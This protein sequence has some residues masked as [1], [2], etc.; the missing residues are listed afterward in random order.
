MM[1]FEINNLFDDPQDYTLASDLS[2]SVLF[3]K[4]Q[5]ISDLCKLRSHLKNSN[6]QRWLLA[7][8]HPYLFA[9]GF[10]ALVSLQK[11]VVLSANRKSS[12]LNEIQQSFDGV[13]AEELISLE[14]DKCHEQLGFEQLASLANAKQK[15][16]VLTGKES[17]VFFTSGSTG[18]AK[19]VPK[20]LSYLIDEVAT[21]EK[22]F[23]EQLTNSVSVSSV[24]HFHIYGL[25]FNIL[26]PLL[27]QRLWLT[28]VV[29]FQE[30]LNGIAE[31]PNNLVFVSSPAFLSRLDLNSKFGQTRKIFS[32]GGPL[33]LESATNAYHVFG[34]RPTEVYGSTET[35]GIGYR[36]QVEENQPWQ[37]FDGVMLKPDSTG[38]YLSS[39]HIGGGSQVKLDDNIQLLDNRKFVLAGRNDRIV[40]IEEK[41][42]SLTEIEDYLRS[43]IDV[44]DCACVVLQSNR[45]IIGAVLVLSEEGL[46]DLQ[47]KGRYQFF[48]GL[49]LS[50]RTRFENV[51]IPRKWRILEELPINQQSKR[52]YSEMKKLFE[53]AR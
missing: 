39:P 38:T 35:G 49:K 24:S 2:G 17:V 25:L 29:E 9:I 21:L 1:N 18:K 42:I 32:S 26:W 19:E 14:V 11:T 36:S 30:Q 43:L 51:T 20:C 3:T 23:A 27:S 52:E 44:R 13:L 4:S 33:S 34:A 48:Q 37:L 7:Y 46:S 15:P 40:K 5:F 16:V 8:E 10:F 22:T 6:Q 53:K 12:W 45:T 31:N 28:E 50:M 47:Q 41:R